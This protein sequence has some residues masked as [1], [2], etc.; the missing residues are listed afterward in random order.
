MNAA[1]IIALAGDHGVALRADG[2]HIKANPAD[3]LTPVL[4]DAIRGHR[5]DLLKVLAKDEA[6]LAPVA[7]PTLRDATTGEVVPRELAKLEPLESEAFKAQLVRF[8]PRRNP[9]EIHLVDIVCPANSGGLKGLTFKVGRVP[10]LI[11][12]LQQV[13]TEAVKRGLLER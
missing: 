12:A 8:R 7:Y 1:D 6:P 13:Q 11:R 4:I 2:E 3:K 9:E 10:G 5:A